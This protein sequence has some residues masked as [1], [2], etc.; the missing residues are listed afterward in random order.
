MSPI[1]SP[2]RVPRLFDLVRSKD[3]KFKPAF[4]QV[5]KDTLVC[6]DLGQAERIAYGGKRYRVVTTKGALYEIAGTLSGGGTRTIKGKMSSK[7]ASD[8]SKDQV[9][10]L[11]QDRDTLQ[12]S[13]AEFQ[14]EQQQLETALRQLN[15]QIPELE[16]KSRKLALELESFDRNIAD[17]QRRIKELGKEQ[18]SAKSDKGRISSLQK[19]ITTADKELDKLHTETADVEAEIKALQDKIMEVGGVKLRSQKAKVDG[20]KQQIDTLNDQSS[21]AEVARSKEEKQC[22]KHEKAHKDAV[23]ELDKLAVDTEK[24]EEDMA[25]HQS[26]IS[27]IKQQA[28]EAQDVSFT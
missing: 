15:H 27:G 5:L 7:L 22:A 12:R 2:E 21:N 24:V 19:A 26:D 11:E 9:S 16:T 17:A 3:E 13:F 10:K 25:A 18:A 8:V 20:L 6:E 4:Y 1:Q 23:K 28:E 14:Q